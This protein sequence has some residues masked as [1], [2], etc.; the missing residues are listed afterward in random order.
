MIMNPVHRLEGEITVPGDKSIFSPQ[1][2]AW[3]PCQRNYCGYTFSG[4]GRLSLL[5]TM[6]RSLGVKIHNDPDKG[7]VRIEGR[8]LH[9]LQAPEQILDA[10][11]SGTTTRLIPYIICPAL[12]LNDHRR[13]VHPEASYGTDHHASVYDGG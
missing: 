3:R 2:Y 11:N 10:G 13:C 4:R 12:Y 6:F 7:L 9:G 1:C 8:G 5:H